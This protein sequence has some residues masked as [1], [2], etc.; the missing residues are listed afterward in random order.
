MI[1]VVTH[2]SA[3]AFGML[4]GVA[5]LHGVRARRRASD[6]VEGNDG[7]SLS[8]CDRRQELAAHEAARLVGA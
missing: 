4:L 1:A 5:A 2:L 3:L 8:G 7:A 6:G